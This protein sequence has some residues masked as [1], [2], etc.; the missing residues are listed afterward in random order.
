[1]KSF[2]QH[3]D[4]EQ[5]KLNEDLTDILW[6]AAAGGGLLAAKGA[7]D[8]WGKGSALANKLAFTP[9]Q[10]AKVAQDKID[11]ADAKQKEKETGAD[12]AALEYKRDEEGNILK[13]KDAQ[14]YKDKADKAPSGW[15][16]S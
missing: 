8:K 12:A 2:N 13:Q 9:K 3:P 4:K 10:K 14:A 6:A 16:A 15:I 11:K 5:E 7:W 1:M